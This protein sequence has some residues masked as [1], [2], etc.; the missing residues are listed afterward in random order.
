[1]HK[2]FLYLFLAII[3]TSLFSS[4]AKAQF[5]QDYQGNPVQSMSYVDVQG[6]PFIFE[7][8]NQGIVRLN[9]GKSYSNVQLKYD[10][11]SDEVFFKDLKTD[12]V[13]KFV[14]QV[15]EFKLIPAGQAAE[16]A[17]IFRNGFLS[18]EGISPKAYYQVLFD[19]GVKLLKRKIKKVVEIKPFNS[20]SSTK[21]FEEIESYYISKENKTIKIRKDKKQILSELADHSEDLE[22]FI[23]IEKLNIKLEADLIKLIA[24]YNSL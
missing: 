19:G 6:F 5:I 24:Y 1:M 22:K 15:L 2:R 3:T 17:L 11:V 14:D 13:L 4:R 23:K 9:N 20:A 16:Q 10:L 12:Q 7:Q 21:I 8:W 18:N